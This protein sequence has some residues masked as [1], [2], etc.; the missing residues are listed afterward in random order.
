MYI[1]DVRVNTDLHRLHAK[2]FDAVSF[3]FPYQH[4]VGL[5]LD[6]ES[7]LASMLQN[8]EEIAPHQY[9]AAAD[10]EIEDPGICHLVEKVFDFGGAHLAVVVMIQIAMDTTLIAPIR[11]VQVHAQWNLQL[12]R[13]GNHF[14]HQCAHGFTLGEMEDCGIGS[15]ESN[16]R[17]CLA[18]SS[19]RISASFNATSGVTSYCSQTFFVTI[20]SRRVAPSAA[21]QM[22]VATSSKV[23]KVELLADMTIVSSPS[24]RAAIA[25]LRATYRFSIIRLAPIC[26][27]PAQTS[28]GGQA[29]G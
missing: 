2:N 21:F 23:N 27:Y 25:V 1:G 9:F 13:L 24:P 4:T 20:S 28:A 5:E 19:T 11:Q 3:F 6:A 18:S 8:L 16:K 29:H 22:T 7:P 26:L 15:S 12:K 17:P 10:C 14:R